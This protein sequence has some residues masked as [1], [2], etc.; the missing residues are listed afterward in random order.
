MDAKIAPGD[1]AENDY[2]GRSVSISGNYAIVGAHGNNDYSGSAYVYK[3]N[4]TSWNLDAKITANDGRFY[5]YFGCSVSIS[6]DYAIV[7]ANE[8]N[9][10][11]TDAGSAYIF[12]RDEITWSQQDKITA[13]DAADYDYF[14]SSVSISGNYAIVG[15]YGDDD[16]GSLSGSA[17]IFYRDG[18][19]WRHYE[20]ITPSD[21]APSD[22]YGSSVSISGNCAIAGSPYNDENGDASG[23][24]YLYDIGAKILYPVPGSQLDS[25]N[26]TFTWNESGAA[27]YRLWIGTSEGSNDVYS[28][29]QGINT[30]GTVSDL[31]TN[32]E[33]LYVRLWSLVN[34]DKWIYNDYTYTAFSYTDP[35]EVKIIASDR[36]REIFLAVQSQYPAIMQLPELTRMMMMDGVQAQ[37]IFLNIQ[38]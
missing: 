37:L 13:T 2:F 18:N 19:S 23:A 4:G 9:S 38:G 26:I 16:N 6:G 22:R 31:P 1:G 35:G 10:S 29:D 27:Q 14:G 24:A 32:G 7:G 12:K 11:G 34:G 15:A 17:Y 5:D 3:Y 28:G 8:K 36:G 30:S 21:G 20:K 33:S 25:K